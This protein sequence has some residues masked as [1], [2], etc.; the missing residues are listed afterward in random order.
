LHHSDGP[1]LPAKNTIKHSQSLRSLDTAILQGNLDLCRSLVGAGVSIDQP[2]ENCYGCRPV[3]LALALD[4]EDIARFFIE[5]GASTQGQCCSNVSVGGLTYKGYSAVHLACRRESYVDLLRVFLANDFEAG[6]P[7]FREP[8][9]PI[10]IATAHNNTPALNVLLEHAQINIDG[11]I[12]QHAAADMTVTTQR[13]AGVEPSQKEGREFSVLWYSTHSI[14]DAGI[15]T[16]SLKWDWLLSFPLMEQPHPPWRELTTRNIPSGSSL[17]I[18]AYTNNFSVT[19]ILLDSGADVNFPNADG[20]TPLH[21]AAIKGH[22]ETISIL[23]KHGAS[24]VARDRVGQTPLMFAAGAGHVEALERLAHLQVPL[25]HRD[26]YGQSVLHHAAFQSPGSFSYLL[27]K[28]L[29]PYA[30]SHDGRSAVALGFQNSNRQPALQSLLCNWDLDLQRIPGLISEQDFTTQIRVTALKLLLKR[31]P[32]D[33]IAKEI[34]LST[35]KHTRGSPLSQAAINEQI[36]VIGV[37]IKAGASLEHDTENQGTPLIAA[38]LSGRLLA[39]KYLV[40]AGANL[41]GMK[42]G[43]PCSALQ[44]ARGYP[45]IAQW[46]LVQ[47]YIEQP[48]IAL[49]SHDQPQQQIKYWSGLRSGEVTITGLYSPESMGSLERVVELVKIKKELQGIVVVIDRFK[50]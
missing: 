2:L 36:D 4:H 40:R 38:C 22:Q 37:L 20:A 1:C 14:C 48:K 17:H 24:P 6:S 45:S 8:V 47:R 39:V 50:D 13:R 32:K 42:G 28:G 12:T 10:H 41:F 43:K 44:A 9:N 15:D 34:N 30:T 31:L 7:A 26:V 11:P 16:S 18:A 49:R 46:L 5:E 27:S 19:K 35:R 25:S 21:I 23:V 33:C 3:L 29:S